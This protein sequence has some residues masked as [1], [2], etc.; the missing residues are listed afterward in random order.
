MD[1][2]QNFFHGSLQVDYGSNQNSVKPKFLFID[3]F[4]PTQV[5]HDPH[6]QWK[7]FQCEAKIFFMNIFIVLH[8]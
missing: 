8:K 5:N 1:H 3:F 4:N 6:H 2:D 7:I